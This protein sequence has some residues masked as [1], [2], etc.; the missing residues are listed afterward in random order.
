MHQAVQQKRGL[1]CLMVACC[2][3][4]THKG[5][6]NASEAEAHR[7]MPLAY[8]GLAAVKGPSESNKETIEKLNATLSSSETLATIRDYTFDSYENMRE[9]NAII[10]NN[11]NKIKFVSKNSNFQT[12]TNFGS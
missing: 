2:G 3:D 8:K 6:P 11:A 4:R 7:Q 12:P 1:R 5:L 9:G 10:K